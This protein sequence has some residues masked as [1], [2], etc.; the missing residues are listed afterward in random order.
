MSDAQVCEHQIRAIQT[1]P[2][3]TAVSL[4]GTLLDRRCLFMCSVHGAGF[5]CE[6]LGVVVEMVENGLSDEGACSEI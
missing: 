2:T 5:E 1:V 4:R 3:G 6:V